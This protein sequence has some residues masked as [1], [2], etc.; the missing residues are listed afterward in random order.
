M[1][2]CYNKHVIGKRNSFGD[3]LNVVRS[4]IQNTLVCTDPLGGA[5]E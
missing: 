4:F 5:G 1:I 3:M 2:L